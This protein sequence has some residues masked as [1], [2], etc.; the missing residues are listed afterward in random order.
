[1]EKMG[2]N[3]DIRR[4]GMRNCKGFMVIHLA[5]SYPEREVK[6]EGVF[7]LKSK[8]GGTMFK[9]AIIPLFILFFLG[10]PKN[11]ECISLKEAEE[12][13]LYEIVGADT[14]EWD[15]TK[16][17]V[18]ELPYMLDKGDTIF[19]HD[20]TFGINKRCWYFFIDDE[21]TLRWAHACRHA[22]VY[23]DSTYSVVKGGWPPH[24][25]EDLKEIKW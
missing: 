3:K 19:T 10:C 23:C 11:E 2:Y 5:P 6:E 25:Y 24:N 13:V 22:F 9:K 16:L 15:S 7:V 1:M 14:M 17:R 20:T 18:Y 12:I 21:P 4:K 8:K